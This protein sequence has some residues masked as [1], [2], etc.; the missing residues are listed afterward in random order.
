MKPRP[1]LRFQKKILSL[2]GVRAIAPD[3]WY[4]RVLY[5]VKTGD[6]LRLNPPVTFNEK[7]NWLK[8]HDRDPRYTALV[9]KYAAR[10]YVADKIGQERLIPLVGGP[11]NSF[12]EIDFDALPNAFVLK[13]AHDSGS[14]AVCPEKAA[15]DRAAAK[16][17]L[18]RAMR[19]NFY[20]AAREYPY[21]RVPRRI[22]A[23][24]LLTNASGGDLVDYKL[25]CFN[26][27]ARCVM[28]CSRRFS[29]EGLRV[30]FYDPDWN[31]LPFERHYPRE[32]RPAPKPETLGEM[33]ALAETLAE[34]IPF[35]RVDFYD[36]DGRIYFG[37][38]TF[39]PGGGLEE[40]KPKEWDVTFGNWLELPS[41][42]RRRERCNCNKG[43]NL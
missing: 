14:V 10:E 9:D 40:F 23:E 31:M 19:K 15:F 3:S 6:V 16:K 22:V 21:K 12:D 29:K 34:G 41:P 8:L 1:F 32:E 18:D 42:R 11:Y 4:L 28:F 35:V 36:V 17:R 43:I 5:R 24:K 37:E 25:F 26:G 20:W 2:P 38:L 30:T 7:I 39:Y 27:K 33:T 13:C